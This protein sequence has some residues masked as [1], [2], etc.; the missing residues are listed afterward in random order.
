MN[1]VLIVL[2]AIIVI[3]LVVGLALAP[4][5]NKKGDAAV[6]RAKLLVGDEAKV[7][8]PKAVG[9]GTEPAEEGGLLGL[10]CL[11]ASDSLL[12]FVTFHP[13]QEWT[14]D[15]SRITKVEVAAED[16]TVVSKTTIEVHFK[17]GDGQDVIARWRFG[18]DLVEWLTELGYDWGPEGPPSPTTDDSADA[19]A[20]SV[21][22]SSGAFDSPDA[23]GSSGVV[24]PGG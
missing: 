5:L 18:R 3:V 23:S 20:G 15:R 22:D 1:V 11:A 6:A 17:G 14:L 24:D 16:P 7:I 21:D 8:E 2:G 13:Q 4:A 10:G 19:E 9:M 12:A